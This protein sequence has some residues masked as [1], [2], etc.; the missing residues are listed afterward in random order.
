MLYIFVMSE[1]K[2][3]SWVLNLMRISGILLSM[4]TPLARVRFNEDAVG[5]TTI[6]TGVDWLPSLNTAR[7]G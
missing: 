6:L 7:Q 4:F 2:A 1:V 3:T 5:S